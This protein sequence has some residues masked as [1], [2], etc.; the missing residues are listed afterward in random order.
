M[1]EALTQLLAGVAGGR[2][3][4]GRAPL[5]TSAADG[6]YLVLNRVSGPRDYHLAGASGYVRSRV[7]VDAY[8]PRYGDAKAAARAVAA[9]LSGY[10]GSVAGTAIQ[11]IFVD[12]ERD[13]TGADPG[14]V[15]P[16]FR[17]SIDLIIHHD[18]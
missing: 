14:G 9:A 1:E 16:L 5:G 17:V 13:L 12:G 8:A 18:E 3:W 7:Q 11:G 10:S 4:W 6:A 15:T 2:R